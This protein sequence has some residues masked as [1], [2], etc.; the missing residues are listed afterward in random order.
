MSVNYKHIR[1]IFFQLV[2]ISAA[3]YT[4]FPIFALESFL[5]FPTRRLR[6]VSSFRL[7]RFENLLDDCI[8][9]WFCPGVRVHKGI[10]IVLSL[11]RS[12][13]LAIVYCFILCIGSCEPVH[14]DRTSVLDGIQLKTQNTTFK[15]FIFD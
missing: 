6:G 8:K 10:T 9:F 12:H 3:I 15:S 1:F 7:C 5:F 14:E 4:K 2:C 11:F 13:W